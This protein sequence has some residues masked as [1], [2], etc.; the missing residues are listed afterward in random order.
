MKKLTTLEN[1]VLFAICE[2]LED[3]RD[4]EPGYSCIDHTDLKRLKLSKHTLAGVLGSLCTK[5][6]ISIATESDADFINIIYPRW[7]NIDDSFG[8]VLCTPENELQL[9]KGLGMNKYHDLKTSWESM[10]KYIEDKDP[11]VDQTDLFPYAKMTEPAFTRTLQVLSAKNY[12]HIHCTC[13]DGVNKFQIKIDQLGM[14]KLV[15]EISE[16]TTQILEHLHKY[17][18]E[19]TFPK[20]GWVHVIMQKFQLTIDE[21]NKY[22]MKIASQSAF[23]PEEGD[24]IS[25]T[26][27]SNHIN[28]K[29]MTT[30]SKKVSTKKEKETKVSTKKENATKASTKKEKET[31]VPVQKKNDTKVPVKKEKETK[32]TKPGV[33]SSIVT[34]LE[35]APK[36]GISKEQILEKLLKEFPER[37]ADK[38]KATINVQVPSRISK[39]KFKVEKLEGGMFRK[40]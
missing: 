16:K 33:I 2:E 10:L 34:L 21:G 35:K 12:I 3:W 18:T 27:H 29:T 6:L 23:T 15:N 39:E 1:Q 24:Q 26:L 14:E 32:V 37:P 36:K 17:H 7:E 8:R 22:F 28:K 13:I 9:L 11:G 5:D 31:K 4:S 19:V 30:S 25:Y 40:A 38:M 20:D